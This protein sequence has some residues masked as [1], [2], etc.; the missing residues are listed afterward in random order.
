MATTLQVSG[1]TGF[2]PLNL[3]CWKQSVD[4][5]QSQGHGL[6]HLEWSHLTL[7]LD[8]RRQGQEETEYQ[9]GPAAI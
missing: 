6:T 1:E 8:K 4:S 9:N 5:A 2:K 3:S 7:T